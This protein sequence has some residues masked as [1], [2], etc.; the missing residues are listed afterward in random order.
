MG[1]LMQRPI[2]AEALEIAVP[3]LKN[4]SL[5][6]EAMKDPSRGSIAFNVVET[7]CRERLR[8][9]EDGINLYLQLFGYVR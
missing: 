7:N 3:K 1:V 6:I 4:R 2:D 9:G 5:F 8:Q